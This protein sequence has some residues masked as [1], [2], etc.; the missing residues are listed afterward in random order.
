MG[1]DHN[2]STPQG[3]YAHITRRSI[4]VEVW[5]GRYVESLSRVQAIALPLHQS[6]GN[7]QPLL[8]SG[9]PTQPVFW[10]STTKFIQALSLFSS[11]AVERFGFT[12]AE[13]AIACASHSGGDEHVALVQQL[14]QKIGLT[15][16]AL[17]C[18]PHGPL[19][20]PEAKKL[21]ARG[22]EPTRLHNN[23]SGKHTGMLAACLARG[24]SLSGY[25]QVEHPLQQEILRHVAEVAGLAPAEISTA[26]DGCGAVVVR[27]S[28]LA[29]ARSYVRLI[30]QTL[31]QPH[32]EAGVRLLRAVQEAPHLV[33]GTG[34]LCTDLTEKTS[35]R[36]IGKVGAEGVYVVGAR[37]Q[38]ALA[39]KVED[40]NQRH[41][42]PIVCVLLRE[43]GWLSEAEH[44]ALAPHWNLPLLNH[45][46]EWV[47]EVNVRLA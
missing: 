45:Q 6:V 20:G 36:L 3:P 17:H 28:L 10:R 23:C 39:I 7:E 12:D 9:D 38:G 16:D 5:R 18:G 30:S 14:L 29:L 8:W 32:Q 24:W 27:A 35:G 46:K 22:I 4:T 25:Q 37:G 44:A 33:A 31:P 34:R 40:G 42:D 26:V 1:I 43:L 15:S 47:G 19:G 21:L 11:G 41:V 2:L 13:L